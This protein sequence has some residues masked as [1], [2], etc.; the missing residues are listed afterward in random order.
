MKDSNLIQL[1]IKYSN[2]KLEDSKCVKNCI[3]VISKFYIDIFF[4][5]TN[6]FTNRLETSASASQGIALSNL[7]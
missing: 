4:F 3:L 2:E 5:L 7:I 1:N 6:M